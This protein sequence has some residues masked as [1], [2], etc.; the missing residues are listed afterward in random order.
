MDKKRNINRMIKIMIIGII[1]LMIAIFSLNIYV[2]NSTKNEIV[3]EENVSNIEGVDCILILGAGIW[4][5]KPSPMLEDRLKEGITLYKQGTTKKIIMSGDHSREDYDEVKIMKEYAES[6]GVPSE[7]IFMDHAGFSSYDS[8][9]RAKEIFGVQKMI[10]VT[11]R[12]HLYR[13]LYIAKKLG[14]ASDKVIEALAEIKVP[15]RSEMVPNKKEIPIMID[16]AHSPESLQNILSAVK[17]YTRG[18]VISVFG[19]GG[20]RDKGKRPLMGEISGKIADFT[21]ITTDNPR[22]EEPEEIVKEIEEG[23]KKTNGKYKVVVD[24]KE[25]I[26]EAIEMANK[27]DII[28]L[29][30]KGHEPYQEING[31]KYPFDERII[32]KEIIG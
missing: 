32:V 31:T 21:F 4:G 12:Y 13:S 26:K 10:I 15:G 9:Y 18:R 6:E 27:L 11:Q 23:M 28:V 25:A 5:D 19:C 3:K 7:D 22:T 20:D 14:I 2:V 24:R 30:G 8:V 1:I 16:Y 17:S 29:A